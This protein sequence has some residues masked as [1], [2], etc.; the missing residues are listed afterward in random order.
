METV[1]PETKLKPGDLLV[2][3]A[4]FWSDFSM[5]EILDATINPI[6]FRWVVYHGDVSY[7]KGMALISGF[8]NWKKI[9]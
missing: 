1:T 5:V 4:Q 8:K 2:I 7:L 3:D 9:T 6:E